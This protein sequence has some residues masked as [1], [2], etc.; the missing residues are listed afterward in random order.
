[1]FQYYIDK[2]K[3]SFYTKNVRQ[4]G[5]IICMTKT[6]RKGLKTGLVIV[7]IYFM[8]VLYLLFVSDRVEKLDNRSSDEQIQNTLKI[9]R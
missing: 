3:C 7:L 9:G 6:I 4:K 8:L 1:M 2:N 5:E